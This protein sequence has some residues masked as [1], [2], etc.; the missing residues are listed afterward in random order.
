[1]KINTTMT[2]W[3]VKCEPICRFKT[4]DAR[5]IRSKSD[6]GSVGQLYGL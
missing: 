5:E 1:M 3:K 4:R 2:N 6:Y